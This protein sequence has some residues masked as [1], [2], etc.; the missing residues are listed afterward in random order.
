MKIPSPMDQK[1]LL[2]PPA[3]SGFPASSERCPAHSPFPLGA[4][5]RPPPKVYGDSKL[6]WCSPDNFAEWCWSV[7]SHWV[8]GVSCLFQC[9]KLPLSS[10]IGISLEHPPRPYRLPASN[11]TPAF[12]S[13]SSPL[14]SYSRW[15]NQ[16]KRTK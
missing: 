10:T 1:A 9:L 12:R 14:R 4:S 7:I 8:F 16:P 6:A 11:F 13:L 15:F 5:H 2:A 3:A